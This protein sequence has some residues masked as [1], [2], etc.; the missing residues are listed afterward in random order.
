MPSRMKQSSIVCL[1]KPLSWSRPVL[2]DGEM[3]R[4]SRL[5]LIDWQIHSPRDRCPAKPNR[6]PIKQHSLLLQKKKNEFN[7]F[8]CGRIIKKN[9]KLTRPL[10]VANQLADVSS[11]NYRQDIAIGFSNVNNVPSPNLYTTLPWQPNVTILLYYWWD[12][13][14]KISSQK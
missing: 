6:T 11:L 5:D 9:L 12:L 14:I 2:P 7:Y 8:D 13:V 3:T 10:S 1:V 4:Y